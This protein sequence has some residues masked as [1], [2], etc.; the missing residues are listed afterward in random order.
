MFTGIIEEIGK[1]KHIKK[2]PKSIALTITAHKVLND[3]L[4]GDSISTNGVCL[5][6]THINSQEFTVDVMYETLKRTNMQGI[7]INQVVNL[8]RALTLKSRLGGHMVS[9]HIDGIGKLISITREDIA[10]VLTI[11][12]SK[13]ITKYI[14]KKGSVTVDGISLTVVDVDQVSFKVSIIPHTENQ[15]TLLI[16]KVGDLLNIECDMIGKYVEKLLQ[17]N[18]NGKY[19]TLESLKTYGY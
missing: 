7:S 17:G 3:T 2:G 10:N 18:E 11:N 13:D 8:E 14:I 12:T 5:T 16:K 6:V 1:V 9:G 15:T 4:V 19:L